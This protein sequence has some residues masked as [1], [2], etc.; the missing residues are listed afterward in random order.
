MIW[1]VKGE[2]IERDSKGVWRPARRA[3]R[4][5]T[6]LNLALLAGTIWLILQLVGR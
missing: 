6:V 2:R 4:W 1:D 5:K 3:R